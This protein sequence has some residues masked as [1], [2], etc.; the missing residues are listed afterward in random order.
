MLDLRGLLSIVGGVRSAEVAESTRNSAIGWFGSTMSNS[1]THE[2][3]LLGYPTHL[4]RYS[5]WPF[6]WRVLRI[7]SI[8]NTSESTGSGRVGLGA[9]G[10]DWLLQALWAL[11]FHSQNYL[12][13]VLIHQALNH[14]AQYQ[15]RAN[16]LG[17]HLL[18]QLNAW[19]CPRLHDIMRE[20]FT[21]DL[22]EMRLF[23]FLRVATFIWVFESIQAFEPS[24][25]KTY[26][27]Y[28]N[29]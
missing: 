22:W 7:F 14:H 16:E 4:T 27:S 9:C 25:S 19:L 11:W 6:R 23:E 18:R 12:Q 13:A 8:S 2:L 29:N 17:G 3:C 21:R 15:R 24:R 26:Q 5:V 1:G 28:M 10:S 20:C